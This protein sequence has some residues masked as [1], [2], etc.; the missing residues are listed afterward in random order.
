MN[1]LH[2]SIKKEPFEVMV[3]GE[4]DIEVRKISTWIDSRLFNKNGSKKHYD[5]VKFTNG[6]GKSRP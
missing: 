4:K 1:I 3:T 5:L 2:L 6:Y